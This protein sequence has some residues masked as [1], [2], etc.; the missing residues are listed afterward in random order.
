MDNKKINVA[1]TGFYGTGSS[2][3]ID[4]LREYDGVKVVPEIG[5]LYEH[6]VFY[7]SGGLFETCT[8]LLNGNTPLGS[9]KVINNFI[10]AM[11]RLNKYNFGWFG[12]Y[13]SLFGNKFQDNVNQFVESISESR[14]GQNSSHIIK[15]YFSPIKALA[16]LAA[17]IIYKRK[18][19]KYGV[20]YL[21]DDKPV[22]FSMPSKKELYSAAKTFTD[23]YFQLFDIYDASVKVYDHLIWPQQVDSHSDCFSDNLKIIILDRDPRDVFLCSKYIWCRPPIRKSIPHFP[24]DPA[25][26]ADEW[27]R[28]VSTETVNPN[29]LRI[30]FEDLIYNYDQ[31]VHRIECFLGLDP[32]DHIYPKSK[33][34]PSK[35]IENTQLFRVPSWVEEGERVAKLLP[36]YIY[37]FPT[38]RIPTVKLMFDSP[39]S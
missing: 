17:K 10:D 39:N 18:F 9:D 13:K 24:V 4:L 16:Q 14:T 31:T 33:F 36:E 7:V 11:N 19:G 27:R 26:Y 8:L 28:T 32:A 23:A 6:M 35:S 1:V 12:S 2:A 37:D 21:Y 25:L 5:R 22:Y 38:N 3:V 15:S 34:D 30:H 29:A 20:G